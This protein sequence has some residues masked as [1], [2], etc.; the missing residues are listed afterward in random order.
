[1]EETKFN[2]RKNGLEMSRKTWLGECGTC[3]KNVRQFAKGAPKTSSA[4]MAPSN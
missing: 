4:P 3:G 2:S 1:M